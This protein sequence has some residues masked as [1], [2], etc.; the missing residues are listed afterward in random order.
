MRS[1]LLR[2]TT[3]PARPRPPRLQRVAR[4]LLQRFQ[5]EYPALAPCAKH[6]LQ[7]PP[8]FL[9]DFLLD[10]C[11]RFFFL[12]TPCG[13]F[14]HR[15][16]PADRRVDFDEAAAPLLKP[17]ILADLAFRLAPS[18]GTRQRLGHRFAGGLGGELGATGVARV[19]V[20]RAMAGKTCRSV[21]WGW[22]WT[23]DEDLRTQRVAA[24]TR[25]GGDDTAVKKRS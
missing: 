16:Q 3:P 4:G 2:S 15:T 13:V 11:G 23:P 10:R 1:R 19:A 7:Q 12:R 5:V 6:D 8:Y 17:S 14:G 18:G 21:S 9:G 20:P 22:K 24:A 25:L